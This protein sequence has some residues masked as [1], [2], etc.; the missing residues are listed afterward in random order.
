MGGM[1]MHGAGETTPAGQPGQYRV[2]IKPDMAGDWTAKLS[3][4][5]PHGKVQA[6]FPLNVKP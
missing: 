5:G 3:V 2:K 4:D 6:S 1:T